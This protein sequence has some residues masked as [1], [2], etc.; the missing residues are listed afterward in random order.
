LTPLTFSE[1]LVGAGLAPTAA[2]R[3]LARL[4]ALP[5][6]KWQQA[7]RMLCELFL[8]KHRAGKVQHAMA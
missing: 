6:G 8:V 4:K 2:G 5:P 3:L 1:A 7:E